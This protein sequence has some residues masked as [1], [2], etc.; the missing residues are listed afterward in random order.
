RTA[1]A[2]RPS[3][4]RLRE[5]ATPFDAGV[6]TAH[7]SPKRSIL[8][9]SVMTRRRAP[10]FRPVPAGNRRPPRICHSRLLTSIAA[11]RSPAEICPRHGCVMTPRPQASSSETPGFATRRVAADIL[12]GVLRRARPLDE[13]LDGKSAH[14]GLAHLAER[15]RALVRRIVAGV[16]RRLGS[17][18]HLIGSFLD[19]GLPRDAPRV[20]TALLIGAAQ[21]L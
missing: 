17:L 14:V 16:L 7:P 13:Q 3:L 9:L 1:S 21:I 11:C 18:R 15:D 6:M 5:V 12:D 8:H 2:A 20:E 4:R 10:N 19:R